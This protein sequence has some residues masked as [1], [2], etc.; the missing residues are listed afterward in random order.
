MKA[1][2]KKSSLDPLEKQKPISA[3]IKKVQRLSGSQVERIAKLAIKALMKSDS[4]ASACEFI[5]TILNA[6][7]GGE[8]N[9]ICMASADPHMCG[10]LFKCKGY[11]QLMVDNYYFLVACTSA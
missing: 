9:W 2:M 5:S 11:V 6:R 1:A 4:L 8:H 7:C 3:T 10:Y